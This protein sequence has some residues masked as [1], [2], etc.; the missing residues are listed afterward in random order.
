VLEALENEDLWES[1]GEEIPSGSAFAWPED[2]TAAGRD[3]GGWQEHAGEIEIARLI[4]RERDIALL[5]ADRETLL[6]IAV[7]L[8]ASLRGLI[9]PHHDALAA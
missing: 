7:H 8:E 3:L 9:A 6:E 4:V 2:A 5:S 1:L